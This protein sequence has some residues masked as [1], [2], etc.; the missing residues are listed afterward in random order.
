MGSPAFVGGLTPEQVEQFVIDY[1]GLTPNTKQ[2][3]GVAYDATIT[4]GIELKSK[5]M[6]LAR[7]RGTTSLKRYRR[8]TIGRPPDLPV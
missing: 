1:F 5:P 7:R 8:S 6:Q 4:K 3:V 2:T